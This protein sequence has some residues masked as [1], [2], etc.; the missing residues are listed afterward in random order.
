M[1]DLAE[2]SA[3]TELYQAI[4]AIAPILEETAPE[5]ERQRCAPTDLAEALRSAQVPM[6]KAPREIGGYELSPADQ[7]A[8]FARLSYLNPTAGWLSFNFS[9]AAG[10]LGACMSDEGIEQI[11]GGAVPLVAAVSAPTGT[12]KTV[13]GGYR[14]TGRWAYASGVGVSDY[15]FLM[16]LCED[17]FGPVGVLVPTSE[18]VLHDDWH[19][20]ALQGTGSVDV[21]VDDVFVPEILTVNP[22]AQKR[23]GKQYSALGYKAYVA[24]E[25]LG[26]SLG[27]AQRLVDEMAQLARNKRRVLD[28]N[29]VGDRGAFQ[30]ELGRCD[31]TL[32]GA[33]ALMESELRRAMQ[34]AEDYDGPLP[35]PEQTRI[36]GAVAHATEMIVQAGTKL[37]AYGGA[38]A[39]HLSNPIQRAMRDL[40][41]SG[42]HYVASNQQ[43]EDW[44]KA[45]LDVEGETN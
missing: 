41:G 39:L 33:Q 7:V 11:F 35:Q 36:E 1:S 9:G 31:M 15:V 18:V 26:F 12:S 5:A 13:D 40:I 10:M 30:M 17:P 42:Q 29:T 25:N 32:R 3:V 24:S 20:A 4:E 43:I 21:S 19:V 14:V 8:F 16:T 6:S 45:I 23:G 27:C 37:F 28:T 38:S 22:L 44:G 2:S 34:V